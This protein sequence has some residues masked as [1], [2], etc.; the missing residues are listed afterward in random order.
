MWVML[1]TAALSAAAV[2]LLLLG[3]LTGRYVL[4]A[5]LIP[6]QLLLVLSWLAAVN[7]GAELTG[8][9][10]AGTIAAGAGVFA[11]FLAA[12]GPPG[13]RR[14]AGVIAVALLVTLL[15]GLLMQLRRPFP[16]GALTLTLAGT[17][18][19]VVLAVGLA[20]LVA[21]RRSSAGKDVAVAALVGTGAALL[22]ARGIDAVRLRTD[23]PG[24]RRR[25]VLGAVVAGLIALG[26]GAVIGAVRGALGVGDGIAIATAAAV[27]ALAA[28]VGL[29]LARSGLPAD[30][31]ADRSRAALLPLAV[32]LPVSV[33]APA[34]YVTGRLLLG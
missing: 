23:Q 18:S 6:L 24:I 22:V 27:V 3:T 33:A 21:L 26:L 7:V 28:D 15:C 4:A 9:L 20:A 12:S 25:S 8:I 10:V 2:G 11:D 17:L 31:D 14:F 29:E 13:V 30:H 5:L 32:L 19:A 16:S 34:A 1:H